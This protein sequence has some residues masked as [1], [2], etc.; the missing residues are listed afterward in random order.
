[1]EQIAYFLESQDIEVNRKVTFEAEETKY[2]IYMKDCYF[3]WDVAEMM[4]DVWIVRSK[5]EQKNYIKDQKDKH[6][7]RALASMRKKERA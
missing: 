6:Y 4:D 1:M 3:F 7:N 2:A 5:K